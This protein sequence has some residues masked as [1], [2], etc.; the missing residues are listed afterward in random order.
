MN[1]EI[2]ANM[3]KQMNASETLKTTLK[4]RLA[5]KQPRKKTAI[6]KKLALSAGA[7]TLV[8][9][10]MGAIGFNNIADAAKRMLYIIKG[11]DIVESSGETAYRPLVLDG[12]DITVSTKYYDLTLLSAKTSDNIATDSGTQTGIMLELSIAFKD[13]AQSADYERIINASKTSYN[14]L[15]F[16]RIKIGNK[17]YST[18]DVEWGGGGGSNYG[19]TN[20]DSYGSGIVIPSD[21]L[22][23]HT[24]YTLIYEGT[25]EDISLDFKLKEP[26][27]LTVDK[28]Q[29]ISHND[30]AVTAIKDKNTVTI[31][32]VKCVRVDIYTENKSSYQI[33]GIN[34]DFD[35]FVRFD[36]A[37]GPIH[38]IQQTDSTFYFEASKISQG[39]AFVI[40]GFS[41]HISEQYL[42]F[43]LDIPPVGESAQINIPLTL[44]GAQLT[45]TSVTRVEDFIV[46][47]GIEPANGIIIGFT[48]KSNSVNRPLSEYA[49]AMVNEDGYWIDTDYKP[50]SGLIDENHFIYPLLD[51]V[52]GSA[53]FILVDSSYEFTDAY[54][55]TFSN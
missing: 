4:E 46:G 7:F 25:K 11:Y 30:I 2:F 1:K 44:K 16:F 51:D 31:G 53:N 50:V 54:E 3:H 26:E 18:A 40:P 37:A 33:A 48:Q 17:S 21:K 49:I 8:V 39:D 28:N 12:N 43:E 20:F 6:W 45:L 42:P 27:E 36:T 13:E 35:N 52:K 41:V 34:S 5:L 22:N 29:T 15:P 24:T 9:C 14:L 23:T 38:A 10:I 47:T 55:F 32:G 19:A